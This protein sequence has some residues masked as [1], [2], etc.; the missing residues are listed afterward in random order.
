VLLYLLIYW[1]HQTFTVAQVSG[2]LAVM[3]LNFFMNNA[4]TYRER[5]LRGARLIAG[6]LTF[7]VSCSVGAFLNLRAASFLLQAGLHW[8]AAGCIGVALSSVWNY[9][10]TAV[11]TWH[12]DRSRLRSRCEVAT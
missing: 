9:A 7:Y 4:I 6:L 5:R 2:T 11:F 12:Q 3:T 8:W 1:A 10:V